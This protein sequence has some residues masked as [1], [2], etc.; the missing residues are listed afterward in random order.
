MTTS[1]ALDI[2]PLLAR[3]DYRQRERAWAY[4]PL[5]SRDDCDRE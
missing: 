1:N 4:L 2:T 3:R 5:E